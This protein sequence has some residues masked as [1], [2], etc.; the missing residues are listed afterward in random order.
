MANIPIDWPHLLEALALLLFPLGLI[1]GR[2]V[3]WRG[4][5][6]ATVGGDFSWWQSSLKLPVLWLDAPRA[7]LGTLLL[8]DPNFALPSVRP[9]D[10]TVRLMLIL[11]VLGLAQLAQMFMLRQPD[12]DEKSMAAPVSYV[13]GMIFALVPQT[14]QGLLVAGLAVLVASACAA[15]FRS[16]H[17]FFLGGM[18][19]LM[20]PGILLLGNFTLLLT[21]ALLLFEPVLASLV[22]QRELA[23]PVRRAQGG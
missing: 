3:G 2:N 16:W 9:Q 7:Y 12:D 21:P 14:P 19:G 8:S 23:V 13:I 11:G 22:F 17:G 10:A 6:S 1:L 5:T 4:F 18:A 20:L 15:G